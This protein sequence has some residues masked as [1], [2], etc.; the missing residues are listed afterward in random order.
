MIGWWCDED[1][2]EMVCCV[3]CVIMCQ[4]EED[5]FFI[6]ELMNDV[7]SDFQGDVW[8]GVMI[9]VNFICLLW[10]WFFVFGFFVGGGFGMMFGCISDYIGI[11]FYVVYCEFVVVFLWCICF[12]MMNV[13]DIY[14]ILWF[15][16]LVW[17]G[18]VLV[19]FGFVVMLFG[20]LVI[21]VGDEFGLIVFDGEELCILILW[22]CIDDVVDIVGLY[23][24]LIVLK[25]LYLVL[26]G[27]GI[28]WFFVFDDV[29]VFVCESL[30]E[31]VLVVVV[32]VI[33]VV[34]FGVVFLDDV[35]LIE[36]DVIW[37]DGWVV[38]QGLIFVVW[39]FFG[40]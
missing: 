40:L 13:F 4:V 11:D 24:W 8:Y 20:I 19:V 28:C 25:C 15:L 35:F 9:Y 29:V 32:W 5:I 12:N 1:L 7:V 38:I 10:N 14:D 21:W 18:V 26:N 23:I 33:M 2:N 17:E 27:G 30:I 39:Q 3:I 6:G 31:L 16:I 36:G 37:V 22:D 34:D